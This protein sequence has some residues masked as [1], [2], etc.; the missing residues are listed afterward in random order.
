MLFQAKLEAT[1]A[2]E[3]DARRQLRN[4]QEAIEEAT[5]ALRSENEVNTCTIFYI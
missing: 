4:Q 2:A 3:E 1:L 5:S